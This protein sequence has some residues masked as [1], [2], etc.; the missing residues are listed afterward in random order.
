MELEASQDRL[1]TSLV[2]TTGEAR[3]PVPSESQR[4]AI[5]AD[6]GPVLVLAGP[7]AGK[8][9]CLAQRIG[10]LIEERGA[11]P[12]RICAFTFTN[13][14]AGEIAARLATHIG[15][16]ASHVKGGTIH[17]FCA[18]LL[19]THGDKVG[20]KA[21]FGIADEDYQRA[22]L[23]RLGVP[24]RWQGNLLKRFAAA[25]FRGEVLTNEDDEK[26]I[27][28]ERFLAKRNMLDYDTLVVKAAELMTG[29]PDVAA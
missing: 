19:R 11:D 25:R 23:R 8:T 13:K 21:G 6:I 2:M 22:A 12:A 15:E 29:F 24:T 16:R 26:F 14:A 10:F 5:E 17:A 9:Y 18:E 3:P 28:Y 1:V 20:V 7:G 27:R 4:R